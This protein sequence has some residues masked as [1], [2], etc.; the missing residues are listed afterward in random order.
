VRGGRPR[1]SF[2]R[3][4]VDDDDAAAPLPPGDG[5]TASSLPSGRVRAWV[6]MRATQARSHSREPKTRPR[7]K[8]ARAA[9][10]MRGAVLTSGCA[11]MSAETRAQS[12]GT[13]P[14]WC[15]ACA[16]SSLSRSERRERA[17][18]GACAGVPLS[19]GAG[20]GVLPDMPAA[21]AAALPRLGDGD[22]C[23]MGGEGIVDEK[24]AAAARSGGALAAPVGAA[25]LLTKQGTGPSPPCPARPLPAV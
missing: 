2:A 15:T 18:G 20:D 19:D 8:P 5:G 24:Q 21:A 17:D 12:G 22:G 14:T 10:S 16:S 11:S 3:A 7:V 25:R 13:L 23:G 9:L 1:A 6:R 4:A